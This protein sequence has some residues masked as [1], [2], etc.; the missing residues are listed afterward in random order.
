[1]KKLLPVLLLAILLISCSDNKK[2]I[3]EFNKVMT[4]NQG[5]ALLPALQALDVKYPDKLRTKINIAAI[6]LGSEE[7]EKAEKTLLQGLA[8]AE[9]SKDKE[10]KYIFYA[11]YS[12]YLLQSGNYAESINKGRI[13]LENAETDSLGVNLT[14]AQAYA[15]EKK[16]PDALVY[17][18]NAWDSSRIIFSENDLVTYMS[19]LGISQEAESNVVLMVSLIDEM[20][21]RNPELRG[22]GLKQAEILEQAGAPLSAL[23]AIFSEIEYARYSG[24]MDND[25]VIA[26]LDVIA[27]DLAGDAAIDRE[28]SLKMV[29]G[30]KS[31]VLGRWGMAEAVFAELVPE[32]PVM[33]YNY[34]RLSSM[35][36]TG[37]GSEKVFANYAALERNYN[38]LQ[39]YY[40]HFWNGMKKG[41]GKYNAENA[42]GVLKN[43]ILTAPQSPYA[44]ESRIELGNLYGISDGK[45]I[46]LPEEL[47]YF[48]NSIINGA[49]VE[50]LEPAALML[51]M[52]DNVFIKD[53]M[54]LL[55]E[56]VKDARIAEWFKNRAAGGSSLMQ[57][58]VA[59][60]LS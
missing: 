1:M 22:T 58:R 43:C 47:F 49:P 60:L 10:E 17:F 9:K 53:A 42:E 7:P 14:L 13:A 5:E 15:A 18:K 56:A 36:Q 29:E 33:F 37:L 20:R 30:L 8:L 38:G 50:L 39:G 2:F 32:V 51:E 23:I 44:E 24:F 3:E 59:E 55:E 54:S 21:L 34:L 46:L 45:N 19:L 41:S 52:E 25:S 31:F 48:V 16:Y 35:L 57:A 28:A 4:E 6:F 40:Y 12:E 27:Q 11:N 26:T